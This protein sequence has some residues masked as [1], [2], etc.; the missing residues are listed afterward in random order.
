MRKRDNSET[1]CCSS[2]GNAF[3][4]FPFYERLK[5]QFGIWLLQIVLKET[6]T[7]VTFHVFICDVEDTRVLQ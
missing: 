7:A 2:D 3:I 1:G 4:F 5:Y 6:R